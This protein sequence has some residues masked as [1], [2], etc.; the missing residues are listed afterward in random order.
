MDETLVS[1]EIDGIPVVID[2]S[3]LGSARAFDCMYRFM[4]MS[5]RF[6]GQE[7][8]KPDAN[9]IKTMWD[10]GYVLLGDEQFRN[11]LDSDVGSRPFP[12]M[13]TFITRVLTEASNNADDE[14]KNF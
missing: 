8:A 2:R 4:K 5:D 13:L 1:V 6:K 12:E 14:S 9:D 11:I 3:V 7:D 10:F